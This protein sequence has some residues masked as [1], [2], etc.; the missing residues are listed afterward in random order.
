[1]ILIYQNKNK[2]IEKHFVVPQDIEWVIAR[3]LPFPQNV[4]FVQAR[5]ETVGSKK[6]KK[7]VLETKKEFEEY[8]LFSF[9]KKD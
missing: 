7:S 4:L 1:M 5:P 9:L 2:R 8:D 3:D 6:E